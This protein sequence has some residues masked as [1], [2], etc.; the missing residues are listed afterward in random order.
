[1]EL[2]DQTLTC[3]RWSIWLI[4]G[5]KPATDDPK[6]WLRVLS[7]RMVDCG[8]PVYRVAM[9]VRP[10]HPNVAARRFYWRE[11]TAIFLH[12][13]NSHSVSASVAEL[14]PRKSPVQA[15]RNRTR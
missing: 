1:M 2:A 10:L 14:K 8:L 12:I 13:V 15:C 6:E 7:Q 5:A 11:D 9:F 4:D 3:S